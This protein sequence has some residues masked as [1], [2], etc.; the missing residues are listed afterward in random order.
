MNAGNLIGDALKHKISF[1]PL[2]NLPAFFYKTYGLKQHAEMLALEGR[3]RM[4]TLESYRSIGDEYRRDNREGW[5]HTTDSKGCRHHRTQINQIF[6]F[7]VSGPDIDG[8]YQRERF[9]AYTVRINDPCQ[10]IT[11][12]YGYLVNSNYFMSLLR[13]EC[14]PVQYGICKESEYDSTGASLV[15]FNKPQCYSQDCEHRIV[16]TGNSSAL[17]IPYLDISLGK[18]LGYAELL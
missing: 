5:L 11:D 18:T 7:C 9:G 8:N 3:F 12:L 1:R 16:L 15:Y 4:N 13:L 14:G 6:L 2:Q 10:F 17:D